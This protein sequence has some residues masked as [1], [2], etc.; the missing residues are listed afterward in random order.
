MFLLQT[1]RFS[2]K[3]KVFQLFKFRSINLGF[4]P[5]KEPEVDPLE[6]TARSAFDKSCYKNINWKISEN[7]FVL[8]AVQRMAGFKIGAIAVTKGDGE[9]GE[10][11]GVV[12]ERDY[13]CKVAL[14]NRTSTNTK[15]GEIGTL[16][17]A[18]LVSVTLD[19][20]IDACMRKM[21]DRNVR[22]LLIRDRSSGHMIG[23]I[24]VKD[25]VKCTLAK[26]ESMIAKL[27]EMVVVKDLSNQT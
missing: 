2:P 6:E 20:P 1:A 4:I 21:L 7:D 17:I 25:I 27:T 14:M 22:H 16:G 13:L 5:Y 15:V 9:N 12:S 24:S 18:N 11:I 8:D 26:H 3:Y 23:M 19:N 10:V